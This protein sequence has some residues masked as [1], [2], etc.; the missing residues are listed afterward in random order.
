MYKKFISMVTALAT[1][2]QVFGGLI[3][4]SIPLAV[5]PTPA[6]AATR[7]GL[8]HTQEEVNCW[9]QRAGID[10]QGANGITCP[11]KYKNAGDV[12]TNSPD[13]WNRIVAN[14]N[15]VG[16]SG[17]WTSGPQIFNGSCVAGDNPNGNWAWAARVRDAAFYD[18]VTGSTAHRAAVKAE[19]L[20]QAGPAGAFKQ[21]GTVSRFLPFHPF[22]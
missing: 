20:W 21:K 3:A 14:A 7:L 4:V 11:V 12:S 1:V 10:P 19:L 18:L 9:R 5:N 13:D 16:S 8:F 22:Y 15:A 6:H 17:R 2:L